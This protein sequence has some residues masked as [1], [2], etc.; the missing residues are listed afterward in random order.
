MAYNQHDE[1]ETSISNG[2][3]VVPS[4]FCTATKE[5]STMS[6]YPHCYIFSLFLSLRLL[7]YMWWKIVLYLHFCQWPKTL[8][9]YYEMV[10][11]MWPIFALTWNGISTILFFSILVL[12]L[13]SLRILVTFFFLSRYLLHGNLNFFH[14]SF[15]ILL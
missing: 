1:P 11:K 8:Y 12:I 9:I 7:N 2:N 15:M 4:D 10:H 14:V 6:E 13:L 3:G 5:P